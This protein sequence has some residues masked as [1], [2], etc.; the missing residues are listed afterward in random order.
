MCLRD[1][2][3]FQAEAGRQAGSVAETRKMVV[4]IIEGFE[5]EIKLWRNRYFHTK[6][7]LDEATGDIE[8]LMKENDMLRA[9]LN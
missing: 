3:Q 9:R 6:E 5:D 8:F 2:N 1:G 4:T 7:L